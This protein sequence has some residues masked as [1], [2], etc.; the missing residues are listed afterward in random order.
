ML[1]NILKLNGVKELSIKQL[2]KAIGGGGYYSYELER[3]VTEDE[4]TTTGPTLDWSWLCYSAGTASYN[5]P[6]YFRSATNLSLTDSSYKC[7]RV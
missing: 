7:F 1:R 2:K 3:F 6:Q 5:K 4:N